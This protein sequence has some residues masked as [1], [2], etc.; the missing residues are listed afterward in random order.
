[1][2]RQENAL[3][4]LSQ[5]LTAFAVGFVIAYLVWDMEAG[6][7]WLVIF[8]LPLALGLGATAIS[9]WPESFTL[10]GLVAATGV[11]AGAALAP[12]EEYGESMGNWFEFGYLAL[13]ACLTVLIVAAAWWGVRCFCRR[14]AAA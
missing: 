8:V 3:L 6:T 11:G 9:R 4:L 1:M 12:A 10:A 5:L 2:T 7:E 13:L 14:L